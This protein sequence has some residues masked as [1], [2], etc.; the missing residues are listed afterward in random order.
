VTAID[1]AIEKLIETVNSQ[2]S[3]GFHHDQVA[4]QWPSLAGA[5]AELMDAC[6]HRAPG[7]WRVAYREVRHG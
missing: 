3:S 7:S 6:G 4:M 2:E 5:L 1:E